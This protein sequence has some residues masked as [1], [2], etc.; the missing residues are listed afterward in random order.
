[1]YMNDKYI[2]KV[3]KIQIQDKIYEGTVKGYMLP[4]AKVTVEGQVAPLTF[5]WKAISRAL[6]LGKVLLT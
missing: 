1:M 4:Y 6:K 3:V 2:G 5:S